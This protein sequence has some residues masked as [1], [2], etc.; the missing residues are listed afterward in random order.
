MR[1]A[2]EWGF[3]LMLEEKRCQSS[4]FVTLT[5]DPKYVPLTRNGFAT[6]D[7]RDVQ[8]Y[9]KRLRFHAGKTANIRYYLAGEYGGRTY[10]PHYHIILFNAPLDLVFA[11]WQKGHIHIG[12]V[13]G[14]SVGYTLKYISKTKRIP[15]HRN[16][17]RLP[18]FGLMSKGI[19]RNYLTADIL[20]WHKANL[21]ER[22][23]CS[24]FSGEKIAMPRYLKELV[25]TDEERA[26]INA[27]M[28]QRLA[29]EA[30]NQFQ[31]SPDVGRDYRNKKEAIKAAYKRAEHLQNNHGSL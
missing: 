17:D 16:D 30:V 6:L 10:R 2:S 3:R 28:Q 18:E 9:L 11:C 29:D 13:E 15:L 5:Y 1:R 23:Y 12:S 21:G 4:H 8:L 26:I 19:G 24:L 7:K 31:H 14:A 20:A 25:Y 27:H 22:M